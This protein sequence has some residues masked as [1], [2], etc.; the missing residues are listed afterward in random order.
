MLWSRGRNCASPRF[1]SFVMQFR[2]TSTSAIIELKFNTRPENLC[3]RGLKKE[4]DNVFLAGLKGF[5]AHFLRLGLGYD[6][7]RPSKML[8]IS[9]LWHYIHYLSIPLYTISWSKPFS[10]NGQ[11][12]PNLD[13][14]YTNIT[15]K[16]ISKIF[17]S[18]LSGSSLVVGPQNTFYTFF[19]LYV[20]P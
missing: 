9:W 1:L 17:V 15:W 20:F 6:P 3:F 11:Y 5:M 19:V 12:K 8:R 13:I 16:M 7:S 2:S 14:T 18:L 4:T 10:R